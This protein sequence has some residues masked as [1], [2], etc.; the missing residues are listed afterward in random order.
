MDKKSVID[1]AD[2]LVKEHKDLR[3]SIDFKTN[4]KSRAIWYLQG[5]TIS[6][7]YA[8]WT[9]Y[10]NGLNVSESHEWRY[11]NEIRDLISLFENMQEDDRRIAAWYKGHVVERSRKDTLTEHEGMPVGFYE[12]EREVRLNHLDELSKFIHP[13]IKVARFNVYR[14][15][16]GEQFSYDW[17]D[18]KFF[19]ETLIIVKTA[20]I[21][22]IH[23]LLLPSTSN[24]ISYELRLELNDLYKKVNGWKA[25]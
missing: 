4:N 22:S 23:A 7:I 21:C 2:R 13:T 8:L 17:S 20:V 25:A 10:E 11:V 1:V 9:M 24:P 5:A 14:S 18:M 15:P 16:F 3:K 12:A 19:N 6:A